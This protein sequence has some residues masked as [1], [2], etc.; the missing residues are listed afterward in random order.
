[1]SY[2]VINMGNITLMKNDWKR[3]FFFVNYKMLI[4]TN[5]NLPL[6]ARNIFLDH[7]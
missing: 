4:K 6:P 5:S 2:E 7:Q 3:Q 1:M